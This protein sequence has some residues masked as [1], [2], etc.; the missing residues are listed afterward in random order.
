MDT[1]KENFIIYGMLVTALAL[2]AIGTFY[3]EAQSA[4]L[5]VDQQ[6]LNDTMSAVSR[7]RAEQQRVIREQERLAQERDLNGPSPLQIFAKEKA[8]PYARDWCSQFEPDL[9]AVQYC[10]RRL[11][12][13]LINRWREQHR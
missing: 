4:E 8:A 9:Y 13:I 6:M 1:W 3:V 11:M 2:F 10:N 12:S 5:V 7:D